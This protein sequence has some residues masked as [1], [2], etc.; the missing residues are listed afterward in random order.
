MPKTYFKKKKYSPLYDSKPRRNVKPSSRWRA[1]HICVGGSK[2]K[3]RETTQLYCYRGNIPRCALI[4]ILR[5]TTLVKLFCFNK[6]DKC[7]F[8][9]LLFITIFPFNYYLEWAIS[10]YIFRRIVSVSQPYSQKAL[11]NCNKVIENEFKTVKCMI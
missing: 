2:L 8:M 6:T 3:W 11:R 10:I 9:T 5:F 1:E 7:I 4:V